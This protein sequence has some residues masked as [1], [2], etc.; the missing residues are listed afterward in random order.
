MMFTCSL[1]TLLQDIPRGPDLLAGNRIPIAD[2][3]W[4]AQQ[5]RRLQAPA[6]CPEY[7]DA[8]LP[9]GDDALQYVRAL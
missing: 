1:A 9:D 2:P 4:L 7:D 5:D 3:E 8:C 6:R